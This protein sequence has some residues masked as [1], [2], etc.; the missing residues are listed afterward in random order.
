MQFIEI[1]I[2]VRCQIRTVFRL[3]QVRLFN[4]PYL[5]P[6][7]VETVPLNF[8]SLQCCHMY[9]KTIRQQDFS[10]FKTVTARV[11]RISA[12]VISYTST[13]VLS[14]LTTD[15]SIRDQRVCQ[16]AQNDFRL[17]YRIESH[18]KKR[19]QQKKFFHILQFAQDNHL[20]V[21]IHYIGMNLSEHTRRD[22][23]GTALRFSQF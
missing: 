11:Y 2:A 7:S 13:D 17:C 16:F 15:A 8:V 10:R 4:V 23:T 6:V 22:W 12:E 14:S 3:A 20:I 19:E 5:F 9:M 21:F 18:R 1:S